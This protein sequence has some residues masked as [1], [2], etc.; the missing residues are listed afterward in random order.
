MEKVHPLKAPL[1][2][3]SISAIVFILIGIFGVIFLKSNEGFVSN[4]DIKFEKFATEA[5][6]KEYLTNSTQN[7]GL[8]GMSFGTTGVARDLAVQESLDPATPVT[9][10]APGEQVKRVSETNVQVVGIDEPDIVKTDGENIFF[11]SQNFFYPLI[12]RPVAEPLV[13]EDKAL[14]YPPEYI[15]PTTKVVSALPPESVNLAGEIKEQGDLLLEGNVLIVLAYNKITAFNVENPQ[16]PQQIWQHEYDEGYNYSTARLLDGKIYIV[17]TR[18]ADYG[19]PCP[20]P[21]LKGATSM[22]ITCTDI[23]RPGRPIASDTMFSVLKLEPSNGNIEDSVTFVGSTGS[24]VIYMSK[25]AIYATFTTYPNPLEFISNFLAQNRDLMGQEATEKINNL[26]NIDI[27]NQSKLNELSIITQE[28]LSTLS[29]DERKRVESEF[30]NRMNTYLRERGRELQVTSIVKIDKGSLDIAATGEVPGMPLNQFSLDEYNGDLRIAT[31]LSAGTMFGQGESAN[32]LYVLSQNLEHKGQI[33]G[34]A[35]GER[36]YSARFINDKAYLVTFKQIDPFFVIDLSNPAA[37]RVAGELK[38][39]GFSSYLHPLTETQILGV[40]QEEG[41]VKLSVFDV[42]NPDTPIESSRYLLDEFWT[43]VQNNSH[44]FLADN[45]RK[46]FFLPADSNGYIFGYDNGLSLERVVADTSAQRALYI[47][48]YLYIV[49]SEKIV[50]LD[51]TNWQ[52]V[53]SLS[54]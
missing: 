24:S 54:F 21:L 11:S 9:E 44:A 27:S 33:Q 23:Y 2:F 37:P 38:I 49:G 3:T 13:A 5:E 28:Y 16:S 32:D 35:L 10:G 45:E 29:P 25:S 48:N 6:F 20:V 34:L 8:G 18:Y 47:N 53:G 17:A 19:M 52:E 50:V 43:E 30:E 14:I 22:S 1:I 26:R 51:E 39:P 36:I 31:T 7:Y 42:S 41:Q 4:S 15:E 12:D 40:G 46:I